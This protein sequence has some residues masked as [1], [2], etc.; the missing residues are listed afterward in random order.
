M[1]S[2]RGIPESALERRFAGEKAIK[3]LRIRINVIVGMRDGKTLILRASRR[4]IIRCL[5]HFGNG[6][7]PPPPSAGASGGA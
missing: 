7:N 6:P 3:Q 2:L 4:Y 5:T 1:R